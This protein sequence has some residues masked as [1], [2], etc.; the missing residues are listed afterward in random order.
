[1]TAEVSINLGKDP[2]V[3]R[4][5]KRLQSQVPEAE[6][7]AIIRAAILYFAEGVPEHH[8]RV[9]VEEQMYLEES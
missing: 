2:R 9:Y 3:V 1:M 4:E 8:I 5:M 6:V 7:A